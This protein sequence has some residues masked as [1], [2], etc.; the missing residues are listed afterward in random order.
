MPPQQRH[1]TQPRWADISLKKIH[2]GRPARG[3]V[4]SV[5]KHQG[6][7]GQSHGQTP[8][9]SPQDGCSQRSGDRQA[10]ART[11]GAA[12]VEN[13]V[14]GPQNTK[15]RMSPRPS[16]STSGCVPRRTESRVSMRCRNPRVHGSIM[17]SSWDREAPQC[18]WMDQWPVP[19]GQLMW[20][21]D[22]T[23]STIRE[24]AGHFRRVTDLSLS[25]FPCFK[26][27]QRKHHSTDTLREVP[28]SCDAGT[29]GMVTA[30]P[31]MDP[32]LCHLLPPGHTGHR[33][34]QPRPWQWAQTTLSS[35]RL[36]Q[37]THT[38]HASRPSDPPCSDPRHCSSP[39]FVQPV[40]AVDHPERTAR[41]D[42]P[43][44]NQDVY[45]SSDHMPLTA[46]SCPMH[47]PSGPA[48]STGSDPA[49]GHSQ[50]CPARPQA[51]LQHPSH[52][53]PCTS[54][55]LKT[56][57]TKQCPEACPSPDTPVCTFPRSTCP[58]LTSGRLGR[59]APTRQLRPG[60]NDAQ[61]WPL[62]AYL[63][64]TWHLLKCLLDI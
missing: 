42:G 9:H 13:T 41:R 49:R 29:Q 1:N 25:K 24:T 6:N 23:H 10:S 52:Q 19:R 45:T 11:W 16:H 60:G 20:G 62:L 54:N 12:A 5:T 43:T 8:P 46:D 14:E 28:P 53:H 57:E 34:M 64:Q 56:E 38:T 50:G 7:A 22:C 26:R 48:L 61:Q 21:H 4:L 27:P 55:M 40:R 39:D 18:P 59:S 15:H 33:P 51:P 35:A 63:F 36:T 44:R 37:A 3:K 31:H 17:P 30:Q 2:S 47:P 58:A 32:T